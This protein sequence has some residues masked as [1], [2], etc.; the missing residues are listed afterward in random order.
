M[1]TQRDTPPPQLP[2]I[3]VSA[4]PPGGRSR[5]R[6]LA[7]RVTLLTTIAVGV[8]VTFVALGAYVTA[9]QQLQE[10]LDDSLRE[11]ADKVTAAINEFGYTRVDL[12]SYLFG[13]SD[14]R[15]YFLT[16]SGGIRLLD[17]S[18]DPL[19]VGTPELRVARGE[20]ASSLRTIKDDG[21]EFRVVTVPT[22]IDD[23]SLMVAQSLDQQE[24]LLSRIGW[25]CLLFGMVGV[26]GAGIA[27][28]GVARNGLRPV[29]RLTTDVERIARTE[30]LA[31]LPVEGDDE[32]ARLALAFNQMLTV[33]DASREHQRR[34]V[35]DAGHELRTPLTSLRTN[36]DLLIQ[37]DQVRV[38]EAQQ[39]TLR[40]SRAPSCSTTSA[41]RPTSSPS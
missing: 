13:A 33:L 2:P 5:H 34:L 37:S 29:R 35:A 24:A 4:L 36:V 38:G 32:L 7:R 25:V 22:K 9:R 18:T 16:K 11:R 14:V 3:G 12:P 6:S 10:Q 27:G 28:W 8:S 17:N 40:P 39:P 20:S 21:Q 15:L 1:N 41:P 23:L 31:P 30:D 26:L 19:P